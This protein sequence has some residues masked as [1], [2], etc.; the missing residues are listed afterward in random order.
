MQ[1]GPETSWHQTTC[2][3]EQPGL[4][5][6]YL[7][8]LWAG[9]NGL[10]ITVEK[11]EFR[12]MYPLKELEGQDNDPLLAEH[13]DL[14]H[15]LLSC[16]AT[17]LSSTYTLPPMRWNAVLLSN[18]QE[19]AAARDTGAFGTETS[20]LTTPTCCMCPQAMSGWWWDNSMEIHWSSNTFCLLQKVFPWLWPEWKDAGQIQG[21]LASW[22]QGWA[23]TMFDG[24]FSVQWGW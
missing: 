17:S 13:C 15:N 4:L 24:E 3:R 19:A 11:A 5:Q 18:P 9:G 23:A 14:F 7:L 20:S 16:R 1:R 2:S 8:G 6:G 10:I 12:H 21:C 22:L